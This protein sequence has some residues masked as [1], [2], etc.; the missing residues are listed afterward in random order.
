MMTPEKGMDGES[1]AMVEAMTGIV[2]DIGS[3]S[4]GASQHEADNNRND[5]GR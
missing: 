5:A 4:R 3:E 2:G 1:A